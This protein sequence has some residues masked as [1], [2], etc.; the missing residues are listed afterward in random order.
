[1]QRAASGYY[2][3]LITAGRILKDL[4]DFVIFVQKATRFEFEIIPYPFTFSHSRE[5]YG[6]LGFN[7]EE[8]DKIHSFFDYVKDIYQKDFEECMKEDRE[9][10][11]KN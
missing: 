9:F 5:Y 2:N 3:C 4:H 11:C 10:L 8:I 6:M 1:M 7:N